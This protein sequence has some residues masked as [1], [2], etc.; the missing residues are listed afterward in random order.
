VENTVNLQRQA[1]ALGRDATLAEA[2]PTCLEL[3]RPTAVGQT[4]SAKIARP[5]SPVVRALIGYSLLT[6]ALTWPMATRLHLTEVG[7]SAFFAWEIGWEIH[8]L[9]SCPTRLGHGNIFHPMR[10]ALGLD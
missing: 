10:Y 8:A 9:H 6:I 4:L 7:D 1:I 5:F 3:T 2:P